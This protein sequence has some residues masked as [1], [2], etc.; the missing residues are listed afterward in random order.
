MTCVILVTGYPSS[1]QNACYDLLSWILGM[2]LLGN[3]I[4]NVVYF[5]EHEFIN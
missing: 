1:C 4:L 5:D 3:K 2:V